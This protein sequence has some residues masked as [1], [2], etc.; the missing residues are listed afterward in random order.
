MDAKRAL[1]LIAGGESLF[2]EFKSARSAG[3]PDSICKAIAAFA[4]SKGGTLFIG[5]ND[6]GEV[7]GLVDPIGNGDRVERWAATLI[8]PAVIVDAASVTIDG[9]TIL[10]VSVPDGTSPTYSY[11]GRFYARINRSSCVLKPEQLFDILRDRKVEDIIA[12]L[13]TSVAIAQSTASTAMVS[14]APAITGQGELATMSYAQ[15]R[16]RIFS[17]LRSA[18]AYLALESGIAVANSTASLAL[19]GPANSIRGQGDLAT[20]N[21]EQIKSR[22]FSELHSNLDIAMQRS[23]TA[24][25]RAQLAIAETKIRTLE[26]RLERLKQ[27]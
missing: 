12:S 25:L 1:E 14:T 22:L 4:A 3:R 10:S 6:D 27:V 17:E 16:D 11:E 23:E 20:S 26:A 8:F 5:V 2:V 19:A 21:Y 7:E 13:R 15:V 18:A 24:T 9:K